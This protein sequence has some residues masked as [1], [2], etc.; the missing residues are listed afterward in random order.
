MH[1]ISVFV[2][3]PHYLTGL[4]SLLNAD[5]AELGVI[6]MLGFPDEPVTWREIH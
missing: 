5:R 4:W 2:R 1:P 3:A 6:E